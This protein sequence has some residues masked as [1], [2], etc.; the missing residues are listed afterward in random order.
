MTTDQQPHVLVVDDDESIRHLMVKVLRRAGFDTTE[1]VDG[2]EAI[3][4]L[5][6]SDF[7]AVVLDVMMPRVDG[8]GVLS[9]LI[10]HCS[11]M[12]KKTVVVTAFSKSATS[13]RMQDLCSVVT[14]PF[15]V[16]DLV[17]EVRA[18]VVR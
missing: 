7:D 8:F 1:A 5:S 3:E 2:Q 9:H 11:R 10:S 12:V 14:K 15:D 16:A 4:R 6:A 17:S 18:C 13:K